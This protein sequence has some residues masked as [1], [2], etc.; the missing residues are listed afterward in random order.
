MNK[1]LNL[2]ILFTLLLAAAPLAA[3]AQTIF[4]N[5]NFTNGSTINSLTPVAPTTNSTSYQTISSTNW[6]P[7]SS[8]TANDLRFGIANATGGNISEIQALFA[9]NAVALTLAGDYIQL[10][11]VFTN[12]SGI[13]C[14]GAAPSA[15]SFGLYNSGQ[16]QPLAGGLNGN[17][18]S[19]FTGTPSGTSNPTGG[20]QNWLGYMEQVATSSNPNYRLFTRPAQTGT[21]NNNQDLTSNG[22][23]TK[24]FT[25]GATLATGTAYVLPSTNQVYTDVFTIKLNGLNSVAITNQLYTNSAVASGTPATTLGAIATNANFLTGG[26]DALAIGFYKKS[27]ISDSNV[28]DIASISV[29]GSV[30]VISSPPTI[31][32]QPVPVTV[33]SNGACAFIVNANGFNVTYQWHRNGTNLVDGPN[34]SGSTGSGPSSILVVSPARTNDVLSGTSGY[35]V[36]VSGAGGFST[37]SVTNSLTLVAATNLIWNSAVNATWDLN[38][39]ANWQP[40]DNDTTPLIFNF[41][42]PVTFDNTGAGGTVTL[43]GQ[44]LSAASVTVDNTVGRPYVFGGSGS[45]AGPG[46][47]IYSG[48]V[49]LTLNNVN[50]YS[51][52]TIISNASGVLL[53]QNYGGLGTGPVTIMNNSGASSMEIIPAGAAGTGINGDVVVNDDFTIQFDAPGTFS[54]VLL[55]N[56]SGTPGKTLRLAPISSNT[57][58]NARVR[59]YGVNTTNNANL[60]LDSLNDPALITLAP[61]NPSGVQIYNGVISG[62]GALIQRA[63]G[64]TFLNGPNTYSGGT[65][66]TTGSIGFGID[67]FPTVGTVVS[68]P[69]GT[70]PLYIAP[71]VNTAN[72]SGT[73]FASGGSRTIANLIQY[74]SGTNNQILVIGGTNALTFSGAFTLNGNDLIISNGLTTRIVQVNNTN[75]LTTFTG[76]ISDLTNGVSAGYG[77]VMTG[78]GVL[79]LNNTETYTGPTTVSNGTLQVNGSLN[80]ASAVTVI[81]NA[82]LSGTGT[83]NGTVAVTAG[84]AI[85]PGAATIGTLNINNNLTLSGNIK[86]RVN[87]SGFASDKANV[88]G[89]LTNAGTGTVT[90]ANL[91]SAL[92]TG[93]TFTLF[94]K[95]LTNGAAMTVIGTIS[96]LGA[97]VLIPTNSAHV[98]SFSL[99]NKTNV[100][101]NATN[102]QSGGTYYLL[103]NTNVAKPLSQWAAMATNIVNTNGAN[104]AFTFTGTN[105][106]GG[107]QQ[108]YILSNTNNH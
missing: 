42:D 28:L 73:V 60:W 17:E 35:Y 27:D 21:G 79:A 26:F 105:V 57:S 48:S 95:P 76:V 77:F 58:T 85:A 63:G 34:I 67:S 62:T 104:G 87:R 3:T 93:D 38:N 51:G 66:P 78:V 8:I 12:F 49:Q 29:S 54:G 9:T 43:V 61:Y 50:T 64:T 103:G 16:V 53:L 90:V 36:T 24:S 2:P 30:T 40:S 101:I 69:I 92:Q 4:F 31:T 70:G 74:P 39:T 10:T 33:A 15:V 68:G 32:L 102:G 75:A 25:G 72:G 98:T 89:A 22:S 56:L 82:T 94:N 106:V 88:S 45:F 71:E 1:I 18:S 41:G 91:G 96:A 14:A 86:V 97:S 46:R 108:F 99:S 23:G 47:F 5:D 59:V 52:G 81:S 84:G 13:Y 65:T 20:A 37:N 7:A 11:V 19:D 100:V 80:V 6:Y 44:Y 107:Q 55:G 83:I